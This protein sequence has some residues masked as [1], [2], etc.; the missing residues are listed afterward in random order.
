MNGQLGYM[1]K[2]CR[3]SEK[4]PNGGSLFL[5][6]EIDTKLI[7]FPLKKVYYFHKTKQNV[8]LQNT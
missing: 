4:S 1:Y 5:Y 3:F 6:H 8:A 2:G 7:G